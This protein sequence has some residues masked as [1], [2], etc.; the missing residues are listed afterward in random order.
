MT[1]LPDEKKGER[2]VVLHTFD[3]TKLDDLLKNLSAKGLSNLYLPRLDHFIKVD[4]LPLLGTG[5]LDLQTVK[6]IA[7]EALI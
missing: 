4:H 6:K 7:V 1:A 5:K 3:K 2:L